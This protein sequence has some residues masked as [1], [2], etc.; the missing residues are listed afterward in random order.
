M[1]TPVPDETILGILASTPQHGYQIIQHFNDRQALGR[2]WTMSTSQVYAVLKRLENQ[3]SITGQ[4]TISEEGPPKKEYAI[5]SSGRVLLNYWL[6]A[7]DPSTSIRRIRVEFLSK[8][9]VA[10]LLDLPA[11]QII[12]PQIQACQRQ[13]ENLARK[14]AETDS[15]ME[16]L[17]LDFVL[18]QLTAA[19][20]WLEKLEKNDA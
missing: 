17:A 14:L 19:L 3:G 20:A 15:E 11:A 9:Y 18:G 12:N 7:P 5:T 13:K 4:E 2:I 1:T 10:R 16:K 8:L 6:Y